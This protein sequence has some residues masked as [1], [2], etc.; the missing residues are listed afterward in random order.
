MDQ[1][2][3]FYVQECFQ[4]G[5]IRLSKNTKKT[6]R[7]SMISFIRFLKEKKLKIETMLINE[8]TPEII[9]EF[10][11]WLQ[12]K[13]NNKPSTINVKL[14]ALKSFYSF[15]Y[16]EKKDLETFN[17]YT[18]INNIKKFKEEKTIPDYLTIQEIDSLFSTA[19]T[20]SKKYYVL[21]LLLYNAALRASEICNLKVKDL[22]LNNTQYIFVTKG[23]G[24]KQRKVPISNEVA[25][26]L[27]GY[28][29][30]YNISDE[31]SPVFL[32]KN[33]QP[34]TRSGIYY[35]LKKIYEETKKKVNDQTMFRHKPHPHIMRHS[36]A[37]HMLEAGINIV[38]IRDFLG[39]ATIETTE[40]Y[41]RISQAKQNEIILENAENKP[42]NLK[43][44]K[45]E[46]NDLE[47]WLKNME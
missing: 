33:N 47:K 34:Y 30:E 14:A 1:T 2:F 19:R 42:L 45:R 5:F 43:R 11:I 35:I 3:S 18:T 13:Q 44:S 28:L 32:N 20:I 21:L 16:K 31:E 15:V 17:T 25:K 12:E 40:I 10:L 4:K 29:S 9:E 41:A 8:I 26:V 37:I 6:Y 36:K 22:F 7:N 27:K 24:N 38:V 39:H 23:K 46:I